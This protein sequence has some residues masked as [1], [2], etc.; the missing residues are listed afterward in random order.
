MK[1]FTIIFT[2]L[3]IALTAQ[4]SFG[5]AD[6]AVQTSDRE[7]LIKAAKLLEAQPFIDKA[8][9]FRGWAMRYIIETDDVSI[10]VCTNLLTSVMDK[11]NKYADELLAQYSMGMAAFKLLNPDKLK[12][13]NAAQLAGMES[14]LKAYENMVKEKPKAKFQ[15][16]DDL[17]AKRDKG[18]LKKLVED[19]KCGEGK[20]E[21]LK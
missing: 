5:Q 14:M 19:A 13:D 15:P 10:L 12:D 2:L 3:L 18:E 9:D 16:I 20:T 11:K 17:I 7:T 21:P 6:L 8:K 4:L 1:K